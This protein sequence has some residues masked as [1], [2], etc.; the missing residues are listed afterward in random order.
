MDKA[1]ADIINS[2]VRLVSGLNDRITALEDMVKVP[3]IKGFYYCDPP[4]GMPSDDDLFPCRVE[5]VRVPDIAIKKYSDRPSDP[6]CFNCSPKSCLGCGDVGNCPIANDPDNSH[7]G[8]CDR[9]GLS[10]KCFS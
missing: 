1:L 9:C 7:L 6:V 10:S 8:V 5:V 3:K 2:T 4:E